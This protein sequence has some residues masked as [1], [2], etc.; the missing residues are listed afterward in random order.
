MGLETRGG[1]RCYY[2]KERV[3]RRVLSRYVACGDA[4]EA[5]AEQV[6]QDQADRARARARLAELQARISEPDA[7]LR[8]LDA[9][10][11]AA[12]RAALAEAGY[13]Q[14]ARGEWRKRRAG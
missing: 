7:R 10:A 14:H 8:S 12:M 1:Q 6:E 9:L 13:R 3:G 5:I 2:R 4:A 11:D